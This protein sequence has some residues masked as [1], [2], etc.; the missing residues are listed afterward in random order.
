M[1]SKNTIKFIQSLKLKKYRYQNHIYSIEGEKLLD[2]ALVFRPGKIH[3]VYCT[4]RWYQNNQERLK[5]QGI[6]PTIVLEGDLKK[7]SLL[8]TPN[9][10]VALLKMEG[11]HDASVFTQMPAASFYLDGLQDPGNVGTILRSAAWF[12]F[13]DVFF[14][15]G[16][17]DCYNAKVIQATMG[18]FFRVRVHTLSL[19]ELINAHPNLMVYGAHM[20]G[21]NVFS[22]KWRFPCLVVIGNEGEGIRI[23]TQ[24]QVQ[25]YVK[26]EKGPGSTMESLNAGIAAGIIGAILNQSIS[27]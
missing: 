27:Y 13:T 23:A 8:S 24:S 25:E 21:E 18:A 11:E 6:L 10:V 1:L 20:E 12:G 15:P 5:A 14:G 9:Q 7:I 26:I 16:T 17:V 22:K 19:E 2:E 4:D 3:S